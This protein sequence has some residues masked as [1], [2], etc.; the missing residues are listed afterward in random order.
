M[1]KAPQQIPVP[2]ELT[3]QD[4]DLLRRNIAKLLVETIQTDPDFGAKLEENTETALKSIGAYD[5][6]RRLT[7]AYRA[8]EEPAL[9]RYTASPECASSS[10]Y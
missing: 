6:Y 9:A 2:A 1:A 10:C 8:Y 5:A 4:L 7:R 3:T